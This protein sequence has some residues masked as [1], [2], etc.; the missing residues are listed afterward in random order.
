M[1]APTLEIVPYTRRYRRDLMRLVDDPGC[2]LHIH[3]DWYT[4]EE[5]LGLADA[6]ITLALRGGRLVGALAASPAE[7]GASWVRLIAIDYGQE[8]GEVLGMLWDV[9]RIAAR[10]RGVTEMGVLALQPWLIPYLEPLGF[11]YHEDIVTLRREQADVLTPLRNDIRIRHTDWREAEIATEIDHA[12]FSP[13]W[14]LSLPTLR[15][16]A[17]SAASFTLAEWQGRPVGYQIT[18]MHG[19]NAIH[20]ARLAV[21]PDAQGIGVGGALLTEMLYG[22][23]LRGVLTCTVN[24]QGTNLQSQRLYIRYGFARTGYDM[25]YYAARI[26]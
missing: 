3:L 6:P 25:P 5:W 16:A 10:E 15:Q 7:S 18:T 9:T 17:R 8:V 26:T 14:Q 19:H 4:V 22:Y 13:M 12:A 2:W 21:R 20:L 1:I 24:T 23:A 11:T